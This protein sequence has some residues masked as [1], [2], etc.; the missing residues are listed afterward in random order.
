MCVV[1]SFNVCGITHICVYGMSVLT[2]AMYS[3]D[4]L[5]SSLSPLY[6]HRI[7]LLLH[8]SDLP[9]TSSHPRSLLY[10]TLCISCPVLVP[11]GSGDEGEGAELGAKCGA[12]EVLVLSFCSLLMKYGASP[13]TS[14]SRV[15]YSH[16]ATA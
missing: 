8:P 4:N 7:P 5:L 13:G 11:V 10:F 9:V 1:S 16:L 3:T 14:D 12:C 2:L 15:Y 6:P